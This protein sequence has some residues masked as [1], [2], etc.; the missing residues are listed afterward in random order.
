MMV[1]RALVVWLILLAV[2]R[3]MARRTMITRP[4]TPPPGPPPRAAPALDPYTVLGVARDAPMAE[5][6]RAHQRM[7]QQY[8]PDQVAHL[9][10]ELQELAERRTKEINA[11]YSAIKRRAP[12]A[13]R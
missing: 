11:A 13:R 6:R 1:I 4:T 7:V 5:V 12:G 9:G 8:H 3:W 10:P 2:A